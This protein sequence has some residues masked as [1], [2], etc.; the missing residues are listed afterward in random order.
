MKVG[1]T[2]AAGN[3]GS[4]LT[5]GL[6]A[7]YDLTLFDLVG[8][9]DAGCDVVRL[10]FAEEAEVRGKFDGLDAVI[11]LAGN[12]WPNV[13]PEVTLRNNFEATSY[14]FNEAQ[15]AGV[16]KIIFASSNFYHEGAIGDSLRGRRKSKITLDEFPTPQSYYAQSKVYAES[17]GRHMA[18]AGMHFVAL[19]I[20]WT[21]PEDSPVMRDSRYM[22]GVFLSHRDLVQLVTKALE[23]SGGF[24]VAFGVS[25]NSNGFFDLKETRAVLGFEP[26]DD[27]EAYFNN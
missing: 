23:V 10:D 14:V 27:A 22:R 9:P 15:S 11:H 17:L 5:R 16:K 7:G 3:I 4:S 8:I 24:V 21:V 20:G 6:K 12:P 26:E 25:N 2:G 13:P 1:I 19:R 18:Y